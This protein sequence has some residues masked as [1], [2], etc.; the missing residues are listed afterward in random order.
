MNRFKDIKVV[1]GEILVLT[2]NFDIDEMWYV[3]DKVVPIH[4]SDIYDILYDMELIEEDDNPLNYP[5]NF[6][7]RVIGVVTDYNGDPIIINTN[8]GTYV[9]KIEYSYYNDKEYGKYFEQT[10]ITDYETSLDAYI[11]DDDF[12]NKVNKIVKKVIMYE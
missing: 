1:N 4:I 5:I 11:P 7:L 9:L 10:S 6:I 12:V 3:V 2:I 8:I